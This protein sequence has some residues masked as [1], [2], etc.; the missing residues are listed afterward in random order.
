MFS[1][2][3]T[4][5]GITF[6]GEFQGSPWEGREPGILIIRPSKSLCTREPL[7]AVDAREPVDHEEPR[8]HLEHRAPRIKKK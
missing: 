5:Q 2:L 1:L 8:E 6:P 4:V 3:Q 7:G